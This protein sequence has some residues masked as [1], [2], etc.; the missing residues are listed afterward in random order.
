MNIPQLQ[1]WGVV[2]PRPDQPRFGLAIYVR[3]LHGTTECLSDV[4]DG[5]KSCG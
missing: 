5:H 1:G 3:E 4:V 2:V